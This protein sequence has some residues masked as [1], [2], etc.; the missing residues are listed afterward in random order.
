MASLCV[1][2][3]EHLQKRIPED[4]AII[5]FGD[6]LIDQFTPVPLTAVA[7]HQEEASREAL[8]SA[9]GIDR[10]PRT[11][12]TAAP[13]NSPS[14]RVDR[15]EIDVAGTLTLPLAHKR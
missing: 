15:P 7:L 10:K 9:V 6:S 13:A 1:G 14:A 2:T 11:A 12:Q 4:V 3:L 8:E 5:A